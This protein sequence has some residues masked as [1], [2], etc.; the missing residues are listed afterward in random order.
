[1]VTGLLGWIPC[2]GWVVSLVITLGS[3]VYGTVVYAHLF[4]QFGSM[5]ANP[6]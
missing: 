3:T 4:G 5:A 1:M 6:I 2:V